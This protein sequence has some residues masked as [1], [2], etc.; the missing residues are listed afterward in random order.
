MLGIKQILNEKISNYVANI[1]RVTLVS[2]CVSKLLM[3]SVSEGKWDL[4]RCYAY[5]SYLPSYS[6]TKEEK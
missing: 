5:K 2:E 6:H 3:Q 4:L 1:L